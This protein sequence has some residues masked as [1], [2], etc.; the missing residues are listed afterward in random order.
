MKLLVLGATGPTGQQV[1][2]QARAQGDEVSAFARAT[3]GDATDPAAVARAMPG[4]DA[5]ISTLGRRATF[6]SDDLMQKAMRAIVPAMERAGVRRI[7]LMSSFGVGDSIRDVPLIPRLM[8]RVLLRDIFADKE[9]AED[10]LRASGLDW[11]IAHP[12]QLTNGPRTG[13]YRAAEKLELRGVPTI[14]RADVAD[15]ML[16]ELHEGKYVRKTVVL[17]N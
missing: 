16:K 15:F 6:R 1:L 14:S 5:V 12:V 11:T 17:S 13:R 8:Y 4:H 3:H 2:A 7:V 9:L 10:Y